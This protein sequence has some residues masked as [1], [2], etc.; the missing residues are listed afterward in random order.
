MGR[1]THALAMGAAGMAA[2]LA[3][4]GAT[5]AS[6]QAGGA[7]A[8]DESAG[9]GSQYGAPLVKVK[10]VKPVART[11]KLSAKVVT[12]PERPSF[13]VRIDQPGSPK[14]NARVVLLPQSA[15]GSIVRIPLGDVPTGQRVTVA[16]PAETEL[17]PGRYVVR[18]HVKGLGNAVLARTARATGKTTLT[19]RAPEP[20]A[21][22]TPVPDATGHVFPVAAAHTYGD[23][24]GAPRSGYSHQGQDLLAVAGSPVVAPVAGSISFVDYQAGGAGYYIVEQG[25][26]GYDYF[27]A[28]CLAGSVV[29]GRAQ[30]VIA[31]QQLCSVG[32]TGRASAPHLH[33]EMWQNGWR[34]DATSA[35][36][37]PLPFLRAWDPA[38]PAAPPAAARR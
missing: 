34:T 17:H 26:D 6:A 18:L 36:I 35:P 38:A 7:A 29:V 19:V 10:P 3:L 23:G 32:Q 1:S 13:I 33:V 31:G 24:F 5:G 20:V 25:A 2:G 30:A 16:W 4:L 22:A 14:V 28:H 12:S 9:G 8:P 21:P 27:F 37:D 11:F 15:T